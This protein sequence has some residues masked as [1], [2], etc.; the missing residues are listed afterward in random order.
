MGI[1]EALV[2]FIFG[3]FVWKSRKMDDDTLPEDLSST[4]PLLKDDRNYDKY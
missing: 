4:S 2:T 1:I 3:V